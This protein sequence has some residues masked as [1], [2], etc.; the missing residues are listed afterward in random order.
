MQSVVCPRAVKE[1]PCPQVPYIISQE[2]N[3]SKERI[4][5]RKTFIVTTFQFICEIDIAIFLKPKGINN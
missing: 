2:V 3:A 1:Y 4:E 5:E